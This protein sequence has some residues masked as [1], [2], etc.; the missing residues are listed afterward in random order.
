MRKFLG[1]SFVLSAVLMAACSVTEPVDLNGQA[2]T[3]TTG[4]GT[5][6]VKL[7]RA[8]S[9][10]HRKYGM[11]QLTRSFEIRVKNVAYN[12]VVM[13]HHELTNGSWTNLPAKYY[14]DAGNGYEI[15]TA[16]YSSLNSTTMGTRF[17]VFYT[18]NGQTY[19]D[20]NNSAD[21]NLNHGDGVLLGSGIGILANTFYFNGTTATVNID[22]RNIAF[23]KTVE[24]VY[25]TDNWQT[26][27]V[28]QAQYQSYY[29]Y[30]Y[31]YVQSPNQAG[32]ERWIATAPV[33]NGN[34]F[35]YFLK[36]TVNGKEY[37]DNNYGQDYKLY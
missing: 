15:W 23:N 18:V 16:D 14:K 2:V 8:T 6:M 13:V 4:I 1:V 7:V 37:F 3:S 36:Y 5:E 17:V 33:S 10:I 32:F 24:L 21:F 28:V 22:I 25:T 31:S 11:A 30:G 12:K 26:S 19:W 27:G 9:H 29:T 20:N 34:N 35:K